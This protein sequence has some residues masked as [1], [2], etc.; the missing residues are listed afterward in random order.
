MI[1]L[2]TLLGNLDAARRVGQEML[3]YYSKRN[4]LIGI[5][6]ACYTLTV[7]ELAA[8]D[9]LAV[10]Q[11]GT[12]GYEVFR[13][14]KHGYVQA[15]LLM[16]WADGER[17]LGNIEKARRLFRESYDNMRTIG[18]MAGQATALTHLAQ[19]AFDQ[20]EYEEA[21]RIFEGNIEI[22][23]QIGESGGL[24][25][26]LEGLAQIAIVQKQPRQ[27][28]RLLAEAV[29]YTGIR[30][31]G[32]TLSLI[33]CACQLPIKPDLRTAIYSTIQS[34]PAANAEIKHKAATRIEDRHDAPPP[35]EQLIAEVKRCLAIFDSQADQPDSLTE[36]EIDILRLLAQGLPNQEIADRLVMTVGTIKWY[37]N[38]MYSKLQVKNR[39]EAV[40]YARKFNLLP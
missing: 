10:R 11:Y 27:A 9:Y 1:V 21:R 8:G 17:S 25:V 5:G 22:F 20:G 38:H 28:A 2:Q 40:I 32:Y 16:N 26:V 4:E 23:R 29:D 35:L 37:L 36:R 39:T 13:I 30:L 33:L 3:Q 7:V 19:I 34:H 24:A 18:S 31:Q 15:Y 12:Q 14:L 6:M